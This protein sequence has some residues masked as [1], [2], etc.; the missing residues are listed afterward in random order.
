MTAVA[1]ADR[2]DG[3]VS[4]LPRPSASLNRTPAI[5]SID[6]DAGTR[7][8]IHWALTLAG[9]DVRT[10]DSAE[11]GLALARQR[12]FDLMLVDQ[13]LPDIPG[14]D[15]IRIMRHEGLMWPFVLVSAFLTTAITVEAMKLGAIDVIEKPLDVDHLVPIVCAALEG[16]RAGDSTL[17]VR[18]PNRAE[19]ET[20][21]EGHI[22]DDVRPG[23]AAE[24]WALHVLKAC[25]S[26]RDLKT[27][28]DWAAY[29]G[30]SYSSLRES[31]HVLGV[32]P[33]DARDLMR[34]LRAVLKSRRHHCSPE[35][36]LDVSDGR[37]LEKLLRRAALSGDVAD[38]VTPQRFLRDQHFISRENAGLRILML[39]LSQRRHV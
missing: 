9:M 14:I 6:D 4:D 1:R 22:W 3:E 25:E 2:R 7:D 24:R 28:E 19:G 39:F 23:S 33:H 36:L 18:G 26:M 12:G 16:I 11:E 30:V 34:V 5:L 20:H 27:I 13:R 8:V 31:C 32:S 38:A 37:T 17:S 15:L 35:V 21:G 29:I 10:A